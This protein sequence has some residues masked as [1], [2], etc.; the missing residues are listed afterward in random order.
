MSFS[1]IAEEEEE[2]IDW[3]RA[4]A[5]EVYRLFRVAVFGD[6]SEEAREEFS[7]ESARR[8]QQLFSL[9]P[10]QL[11]LL[12]EDGRVLINGVPLQGSASSYDAL[13]KVA[14]FLEEHGCNELVFD[15]GVRP[16]DVEA[17]VDLLVELDAGGEADGAPFEVTDRARLLET[18]PAVRFG[19]V[20][21]LVGEAP[22][23]LRMGRYYAACVTA[24]RQYYRTPPDRRG[25]WFSTIKRMS[26]V[27]VR[28]SRRSRPT[29]LALTG[30]REVADD[31]AACTLNGALL[32]TLMARRLTGRVETLG[33]IAFAALIS[34]PTSV[35]ADETFESWHTPAECAAAVM[36]NARTELGALQRAVTAFEV[37]WMFGDGDD[38]LP[39]GESVRPRVETLLIGIAREY[40]AR[41][42]SR[43]SEGRVQS[44]R[45]VV[46]TI[47]EHKTLRVERYLLRL[48]V[49]TLG[50]FTRGMYVELSSGWRGVVL[51]A[52]NHVT[53]FHLPLVRLLRNPDGEEVSTVDVDLADNIDGSSRFGYAVRRLEDVDAVTDIHDSMS[54]S[55]GAPGD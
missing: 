33:R 6:E 25:E 28:L 9:A 52:N 23:E 17:V 16:S 39:Y 29:T 19:L 44:P 34:D 48:L 47:A 14:R 35:E 31:P 49:D 46:E 45:K 15:E 24:L 26:Q 7:G 5:G 22:I 53:D 32:A 43:W 38:P 27:W 18:D 41:V 1:Q 10:P 21:P 40:V 37:E 30:L 12:F 42:A 36:G 51:E 11:S 8:L 2:P 50:L 3:R 55:I 13:D 20:D 4:F 54:D